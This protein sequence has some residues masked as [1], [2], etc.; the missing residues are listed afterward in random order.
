MLELSSFGALPYNMMTGFSVFCGG[1]AVSICPIRMAVR[2]V[3][4]TV[5]CRRVRRGLLLA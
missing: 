2:G 5:V 4:V 3:C 1:L